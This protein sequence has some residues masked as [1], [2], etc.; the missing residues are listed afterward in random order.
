VSFKT[1]SLDNDLASLLGVNIATNSSNNSLANRGFNAPLNSNEQ[2][3]D[4][5][6][7]DS[8]C[9]K[10]K[11]G[12]YCFYNGTKYELSMEVEY[13]YVNRGWVRAFDTPGRVKFILKPG[14]SRCVTEI[15]AGGGTK[16]H[17]VATFKYTASY[18]LQQ[19]KIIDEGDFRVQKCKSLTYNIR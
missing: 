15:L 5:N 11:T 6:T 9:E 7:V 16:N 14:E 18:G 2:R 12:D 4:P 10:N 13:G 8:D 17:F 3:N 1:I 19:D